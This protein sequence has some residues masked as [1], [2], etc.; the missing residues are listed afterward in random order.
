MEGSARRDRVEVGFA[1]REV[2][3]ALVR[4]DPLEGDDIVDD[5]EPPAP[6]LKDRGA[7]AAL[8]GVPAD[9]HGA[10]T[11]Q[12][13]VLDAPRNLRAVVAV[14]GDGRTLEPKIREIFELSHRLIP[15]EARR[16][17]SQGVTDDDG[18]IYYNRE[19]PVNC[20]L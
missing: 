3:E 18:I 20:P 9:A 19:N 14:F 12:R 11:V 6:R 15:V 17:Q 4:G 13:T 5:F 16:T 1:V 10:V 7:V 2:G 8:I